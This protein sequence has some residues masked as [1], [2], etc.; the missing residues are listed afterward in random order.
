MM[1][2]NTVVFVS[3]VVVS[4]STIVIAT[5]TIVY[6]IG[7]F[8]L[9]R[10]T[11]SSLEAA[12]RATYG[13]TIQAIAANH[14]EIAFR[15]LGSEQLQGSF[16]ASEPR[17]EPLN[18]EVR[19]FATVLINHLEALYEHCRFN[20]IPKEFEEPLLRDIQRTMRQV[21]ALRRRWK[22]ME[23]QLEPEFSAFVNKALQE[24]TP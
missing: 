6:T 3:S 12:R 5:A 15:A 11:Q 20:T 1:D 21:P 9:W 18:A 13:T 8:R 22:E 23:S 24:K 19:L 10:T 2:A 17:D 4:I 7:T 16:M 14:R